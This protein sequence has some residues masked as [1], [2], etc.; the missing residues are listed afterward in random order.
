[1]R[2]TT[3]C[4]GSSIIVVGLVGSILISGDLFIRNTEQKTQATQ[5]KNA[6]SL[7]TL[8]QINI[9]V[10]NQ[11]GALKDLILLHRDPGKLIKYRNAHSQFAQYLVDLEKL[12]PEIQPALNKI[13]DRHNLLEHL[14]EE[15]TSE[16]DSEKPLELASSQ[17]D[18]RVINAFSRDIEL[19]LRLLI[20]NLQQ[21]DLITKQDFHQFKQNTQV[22]KQILILSILLVFVGHLLLIILPVIRSIQKLQLG[23]NTIGNGDLAYRLDIKTQDEIEELANAFNKMAETLAESYHDLEL[24]KELAD[25]ANHAKSQFLANMSHELRTPLNGILGYAQILQRDKQITLKQ[26]DGLRI[27]H[28]CANHLL[29]LIN[30]ILDLSKIEAQKMDLHKHDFHFPAFLQSVVEICRIRAEQKGISFIYQAISDLPIA[31]WADEKRLRQV[32]INLLGNA[33][34]FTEIG[35]VQFTVSVLDKSE[36]IR[37]ELGYREQGIED[38]SAFILSSTMEKSTDYIHPSIYKI[39]FKIVDTGVGM[40]PEQLEKIFLPFEQVGDTKKQSEGTGLGLAISNKIVQLMGSN[41]QVKSELYQGSTFWIDLDLPESI[42]WIQ[43]ARLIEGS[44]IVG[45][46]D[47]RKPNILVV[48]DKWENRSVVINILGELGFILTEASNGQEALEQAGKILPDLM[49]TDLAMPVMDGFELTRRLR[50]LP[51]FDGLKIIVSS[52]S[53]FESD[54]HQSLGVGADDFLAKPVQANELL[55]KLQQHLQLEWIYDE[56]PTTALSQPDLRMTDSPTTNHSLIVPAPETIEYLF[57]LAMR[58]NIRLIKE[59]AEKLKLSDRNLTNFA[60]RIQELA[61]SF[62][63]EKIR[64]FLQQ[65]RRGE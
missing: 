13:R 58:G 22:A 19:H 43:S 1:M 27:I 63:L 17:Q 15:L 33:I 29:T 40:K 52:A 59:E 18:F 45:I 65:Y 30:D 12:Q 16:S 25:A 61:T 35:G 6:K 60:N 31:I 3:K 20:Q 50:K 8:L 7:T 24:K 49:I 51:E 41:I 36:D 46:A 37:Q 56:C 28:Q 5:D 10:N 54:Q 23:A 62:Q 44:K 4:I 9:A 2:I 32:L 34:K 39:R 48:D 11:V 14:V 21:K 64:D 53:V 26:Q 38:S 57:D 55:Q 47:G 42:D